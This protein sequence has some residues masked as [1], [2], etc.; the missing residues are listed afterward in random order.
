LRKAA[1]IYRAA[2]AH[3]RQIFGKVHGK[4]AAC[5]VGL[6]ETYRDLGEGARARSLLLR[7]ISIAEESGDD[8]VP[9]LE[10]KLEELRQ[11]ML[12]AA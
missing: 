1:E 3:R 8:S 7:A 12:M 2:M 10:P 4:V 5:I 11:T 9:A 6:A